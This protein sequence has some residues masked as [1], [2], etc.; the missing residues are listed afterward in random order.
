MIKKLRRKFI[1][2]SM[3]SIALVMVILIGII[4]GLNYNNVISNIDNIIDIIASNGGRFPDMTDNFAMPDMPD[5]VS[6][7][8]A[9]EKPEG[10]DNKGPGGGDDKGGFFS[11]FRLILTGEE[12]MFSAETQYETRYF[13]VTLTSDGS[14][15]EIDTGKI[16][17]VD[18]DKAA[19]YAEIVFE[20]GKE[21][22]IVDDYR[23]RMVEGESEILIVFCYCGRVMDS[24]R[25][26]LII[27]VCITV[28]CLILVFVIILIASGRVIRPA[29]EQ[30][31]KQRRFITD[32]GHELKTPLAIINAD[33]EVV[34]DDLD[35]DSRQWTDDIKKQVGRLTELTNE[36]IF[37]A[38]SEEGK[39]S[40][41]VFAEFSLS[42]TARDMAES[43]RGAAVAS[44]KKFSVDVEDG[45]RFN[46]EKKSIERLISILMDNAIKYSPEDG[47]VKF[48][49]KRSGKSAFVTVFNTCTTPVNQEDLKHMFDRFY[50]SDKSRNSKTGGYGIGLSI[51]KSI[52]EAHKG[53]IQAQSPDGKS[54][55]ITVTLKDVTS[56]VN[57][58]VDSEP[59]D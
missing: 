46:G 20:V 16:S 23:Y 11:E 52:T 5:G 26:F 24:A 59:M 3:G 8:D 9:P 32:A 54:M 12:S 17:S 13:S 50:R 43:F 33:C 42:D 15:S 2:V 44:G 56:G 49:L 28:A 14:I 37:L 25:D 34:E 19:E 27:S 48:S 35:E 22:G 41:M 31:E 4:N 18:S 10:E 7:G 38:K 6:P 57:E 39:T 21:R 53:K 36:L 30:Y 47:E 40:G 58:E 1:A 55:K 45:I 51:A 29:A